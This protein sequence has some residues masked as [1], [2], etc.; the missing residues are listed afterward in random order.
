MSPLY[1]QP[2]IKRKIENGQLAD[3][4]ATRFRTF[5]DTLLQGDDEFPCHFAVFAFKKKNMRYLFPGSPDSEEARSEVADGLEAF[6][7]QQDSLHELTSLVI[8]FEPR[9][10]ELPAEQYKMD[11]WN[12]LEYL[13][14]N[15]PE[16]WP[17]SI[18]RDPSHPQWTLCFA[19]EPL[20]LVGRAPFYE[21][22]RSRYTEHDLEITIQPRSVFKR[23]AGDTERGMEAR[24]KVRERL[25]EYDDI[26]RHPDIGNFRDDESREWRQYMLPETNEESVTRFPLSPRRH[27]E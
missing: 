19:G 15:D 7:D 25:A 24:R 17:E 20:F 23:F 16:P 26:E 10:E 11:F 14:Q 1:S 9:D 2:E 13:N 27:D 6:I 5:R 8:L 18:P 21:K 3:W 12:V 4:K 22:R